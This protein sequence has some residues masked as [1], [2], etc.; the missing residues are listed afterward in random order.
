[1]DPIVKRTDE[2]RDEI[3]GEVLTMINYDIESKNQYL[4]K[5][6]YQLNYGVQA[7]LPT[8]YTTDA[9]V[10]PKDPKYILKSIKYALP[11]KNNKL[12]VYPGNNAEGNGFETTVGEYF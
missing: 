4:N 8:F 7:Q 5:A 2:V 6:A 9:K 11:D 10:Y 3:T 1:M 12:R